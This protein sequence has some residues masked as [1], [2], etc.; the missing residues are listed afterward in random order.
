[1]QITK[2]E[3]HTTSADPNR[4]ECES[5]FAWTESLPPVSYEAQKRIENFM[6]ECRKRGIHVTPIHTLWAASQLI[7]NGEQSRGNNRNVLIPFPSQQA[8]ETYEILSSPKEDT[9]LT[10][11]NPQDTI[12]NL[13]TAFLKRTSQML[14]CSHRGE[15]STDSF[16]NSCHQCRRSLNV[17]SRIPSL[18]SIDQ[19]W[20]RNHEQTFTQPDRLAFERLVSTFLE[21]NHYDQSS[22][23][24]LEEPITPQQALAH[25]RIIA[26][27]SYEE[28]EDQPCTYDF[29]GLGRIAQSC[30]IMTRETALEEINKIVEKADFSEEERKQAAKLIQHIAYR[31]S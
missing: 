4:Q 21:Q 8:E 23:V 19:T 9:A 29:R 25:L 7:K 12:G 13:S 30:R 31:S 24:S 27:P 11:I 28:K 15:T 2:F 14:R 6:T 26:G 16:M 10:T 1:M 3:S 20:G 17:R 5:F 22:L 18:K